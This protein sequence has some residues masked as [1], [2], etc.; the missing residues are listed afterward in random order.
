MSRF[1]IVSGLP[2]SGKSTIAAALA[3]S[4]LL[5]LI[6][7][8]DLLERL[9]QAEGALDVGRRQEL[10]RVADRDFARR[11]RES[12]GAI[13]ASWWRHPHS[14]GDSGTPTA[15]LAALPGARIEVYCQCDPAQAAERFLSR[16]RHPGHLDGRWTYPALLASFDQQALLGPLRIGDLIEVDTGVCAP[17]AAAIAKLVERVKG[18]DISRGN[19]A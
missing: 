3:T 5:P 13:L 9:F 4:L 7:K 19:R 16:K 1:I 2:A 17:T 8:D 10:S 14:E 6:D 12:D 18:A 11:A 15:W